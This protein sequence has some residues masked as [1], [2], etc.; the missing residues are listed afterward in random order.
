MSHSVLIS[1]DGDMV[2][3]AL[4]KSKNSSKVTN[5]SLIPTL[6]SSLG[7]KIGNSA[8]LQVGSQMEMTEPISF[9]K[10][11]TELSFKYRGKLL[12]PRRY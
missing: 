10:Q 2:A 1:R 9:L 11:S 12:V 6:M 4:L 7:P 5:F 3:N 8:V